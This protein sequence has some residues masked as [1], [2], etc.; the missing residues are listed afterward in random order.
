MGAAKAL[1]PF[2]GSTFIEDIATA[3]LK[4]GADGVV[5][6]LSPE[7]ALRLPQSV[8][9]LP[10][11]LNPDP[12]TDMIASVRLGMAHWSELAVPR[13]SDGLLVCPVDAPG[14]PARTYRA[15]ADAFRNAP[16]RIVV[17]VREGRRGHPVIFPYALADDV[18]SVRCAGGLRSLFQLHPQRLLTIPTD[19]PAIHRNVNRPEDQEALTEDSSA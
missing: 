12:D 13:H 8:A 7:L 6:V 11:V 4:S 17:P 14:I 3:M 2:S 15:C 18:N 5:L 1:L 10:L 16:D 9:A 19:A